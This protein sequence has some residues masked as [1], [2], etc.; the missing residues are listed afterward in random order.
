M[1]KLFTLLAFVFAI[2]LSTQ[3]GYSQGI[4]ENAEKPDIVA[5]AQLEKVSSS[6]NLSDDQERT[7]FRV[8]LA[9]EVNLRKNVNGKDLENPN[10][11]YS[12]KKIAEN[13][14]KGMKET[15]TE[16]QFSKWKA[17]QK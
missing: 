13:F 12:V 3:S 9:R 7:L 14:E 17:S 5:K 15:L 1:K 11:S 6:L 10:V 8:F 16:D 2:A 4:T